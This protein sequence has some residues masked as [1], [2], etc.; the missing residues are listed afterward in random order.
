MKPHECHATESSGRIGARWNVVCG[1]DRHIRQTE[2]RWIT[3]PVDRRCLPHSGSFRS[4]LRS[5]SNLAGWMNWG[6]ENS[7]GHYLDLSSAILGGTLFPIG[8][9]LHALRRQ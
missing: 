3:F 1:L 4:R 9:L 6:S 2:G 8:Y 7:A 5:S